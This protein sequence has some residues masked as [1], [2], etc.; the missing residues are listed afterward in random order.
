MARLSWL[1]RDYLERHAHPTNALL[2]IVGVP[3]ALYGLIRL[4]TG[5]LLGGL[6]WLAAG[7]FFQWLG[8]RAQGNEVGEWM[9]I[10][11]LAGRLRR[12]R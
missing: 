11:T 9:L 2:H 6:T 1:F 4:L 3:A 10:K 7:Y 5:G 12:R 8:H